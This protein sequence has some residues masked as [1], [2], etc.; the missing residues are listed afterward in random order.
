MRRVTVLTVLIAALALTACVLPPKNRQAAQPLQSVAQ[1]DPQRYAGAWR[2]IATL[3]AFFQKDCAASAAI[4]GVRPDGALSVRNVC[5]TFDGKTKSIV[6]KATPT[7]ATNAK[8]KVRFGRQPFAGDYWVIHLDPDYRVA[9]VGEPSGRFLWILA[10]SAEPDAPSID[11]AV[12]AARALGYDTSK[13]VYDDLTLALPDAPNRAG[14][15]AL[16]SR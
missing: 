3:P 1:V 9:V 14:T 11:A 12:S 4:Y 8:L 5:Q 2:Q 10:R 13:L 6:G 15:A 16:G 7:D